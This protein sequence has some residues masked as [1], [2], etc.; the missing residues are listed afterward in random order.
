[1][2]V[3]YYLNDNIKIPLENFTILS[4][5]KKKKERIHLKPPKR[6]GWLCVRLL[7][8]RTNCNLDINFSFSST[9]F[10]MPI[11]PPKKKKKNRHTW[12]YTFLT[13]F[14]FSNHTKQASDCHVPTKPPQHSSNKS[15]ASPK[16]RQE[17]HDNS[18]SQI[19]IPLKPQPLS[20]HLGTVNLGK[21]SALSNL[22]FFKPTTFTLH[23]SHYTK[24]LS[25]I[26][27]YILV[28]AEK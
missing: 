1:M 13:F 10:D 17:N 25:L 5:K 18:P 8:K 23:I 4:K 27:H 15:M 24:I 7:N 21:F 26:Y 19:H 2:L 14:S 9:K 28:H 6:L 16:N 20:K 3:K 11:Q 12:I 22:N